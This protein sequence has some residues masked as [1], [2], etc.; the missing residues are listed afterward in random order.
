[1]QEAVQQ[2]LDT[3]RGENIVDMAH[4]VGFFEGEL[5][6]WCSERGIHHIDE[7]SLELVI[8]FRNSLKNK[9]SVRNRKLSRLR[10]FFQ[11]CCD[12]RWIPENSTA[13]ARPLSAGP[14]NQS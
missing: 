8:K 5:L 9:G 11:F 7:L 6:R 13:T 14:G 4:Y 12:L 10:T 1:M 3:K 2:F